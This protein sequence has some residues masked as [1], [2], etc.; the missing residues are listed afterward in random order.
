MATP[1]E[2]LEGSLPLNLQQMRLWR[3][4]SWIRCVKRS[5]QAAGVVLGYQKLH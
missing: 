3:P 1:S 5:R 4:K 2:Y